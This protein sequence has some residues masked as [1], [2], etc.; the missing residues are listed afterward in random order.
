MPIEPRA[1]WGI[2]LPA[3][4]YSP[5]QESS[6]QERSQKSAACMVCPVAELFFSKTELAS[7]FVSP[8]QFL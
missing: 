8:E 2:F 5:E 4:V 3:T 6:K 7:F 1:S